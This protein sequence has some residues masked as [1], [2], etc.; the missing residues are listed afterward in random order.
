M[1][2]SSTPPPTYTQNKSP[3][4]K[5]LSLVPLLNTHKRRF[6]SDIYSE[7]KNSKDVHDTVGLWGNH[8]LLLHKIC[9]HVTFHQSFK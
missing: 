9:F 5:A 2:L 7:P 3:N 1:H 4:F 6:S 8:M